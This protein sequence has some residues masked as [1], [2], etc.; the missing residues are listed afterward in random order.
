MI[1]A[2]KYRYQVICTPGHSPDHICLYEQERGWLFTGDL[3]V[4]G[5]DRALRAGYDIW[6]II[7]SLKRVAALPLARLFPGSARVRDNPHQA[8]TEKIAYLEET[9]RRVLD[10]S[11]QGL[12]VGAIARQLFGG[13]MW[14]ELITAGHFTRSWLVRSY[15]SH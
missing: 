2:G 13:P 3:F 7:A 11:Q 5:R 8:L 10:L 14:I 6:Q 1:A 4:G 15:L 12:D 9:G